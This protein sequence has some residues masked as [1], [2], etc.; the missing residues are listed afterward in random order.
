VTSFIEEYPEIGGELLDHFY[1][2]DEARKAAEDFYC[3]CSKS[4]ADKKASQK[5]GSRLVICLFRESSD[6]SPDSMKKKLFP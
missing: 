1:G 6:L 4:M 3:A 2:I 5:Q